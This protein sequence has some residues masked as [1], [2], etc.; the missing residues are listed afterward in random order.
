MTITEISVVTQSPLDSERLW[1]RN[2]E[3]PQPGSQVDGHLVD[4]SGWVLGRSSPVVAVEVVHENTVVQRVPLNHRR[5]DLAEAFPEVPGA[6][7]SGFRTTV[8]LLGATPELELRVQAVL[9]DQSRVALGAIRARRRWREGD[10]D[11]GVALVSV[12]IPCYNQA[13]FLGE[14]IESVLSQSYPH[15]EV[16]VVD[17]G[18][19]DNTQ[20]VAARYPGVRCIRQ[21]N[22]G[23]AGARN[24]GIRHSNGSFLVFLDADDR[25]LA[26]ALEAGLSSLKA[27]PECAF[28]FGSCQH[29]AADG[30]PLPTA[31][32]P[33]AERDYYLALLERNYI[34]VSAVVMYR[35]AVFEFVR[36]F[37][38]SASPAEDYELYLRVARDYPVCCHERV[39]AEYRQHG[40]NTPENPEPLLISTLAVLLSQRRYVKGSKRH[41]QEYKIAVKVGRGFYGEQ[42]VDETRTHMRERQWRRALRGML[43]LLRYY[44]RGFASVLR[45]YS[46]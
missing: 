42:L 34:A 29:I 18:S 43:T 5:P 22:Q 3:S 33:C 41:G 40:A 35:R 36:G 1:G 30:S 17:D 15:F 16:V 14:A 37:D 32:A 39:I 19:T 12:I 31:Q 7:E 44:P 11:A 13:H 20:E 9:Q 10:Y 4:L 8:S 6:Q 26:D 27:H 25:L 24:T 46:S 2:I 28:A 23:L 38:P 45:R 21:E